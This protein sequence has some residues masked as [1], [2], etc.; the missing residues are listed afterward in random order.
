MANQQATGT[1]RWQG[2][3]SAVAA[4]LLLAAL[5][6]CGASMVSWGTASG[7]ESVKFAA[8]RDDV[9]RVGREELI[10]FYTLDYKNPDASFDRLVQS[11]TG[12][13]A[14][15]IKQG[16]ANWKKQLADQ[17]T[18]S[19]AKVL[20][21][22]VTELDDRAGTATV[23]AIVQVDVTPNNGKPA[24]RLPM[25]IQLTRTDQGWKLSQAGSIVLGSQ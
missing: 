2:A 10:N 25:Q 23:V 21:A 24:N 6:F 20:D 3:L 5:I 8:T 13:L 15:A 9:L 7:D 16:E 4:V 18:S 19:T 11:S 12:D 14:T 22:A 1:A 17:K